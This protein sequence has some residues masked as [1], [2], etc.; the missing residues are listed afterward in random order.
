MS[1]GPPTQ[2]DAAGP[3]QDTHHP[4]DLVRVDG[5]TGA[6]HWICHRC[7]KQMLLWWPPDFKRTILVPG[8]ERAQHS[9]SKGG[10]QVGPVVTEVLPWSPTN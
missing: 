1:D 6:E 5:E 8:D 9:A 2:V 4:M 7:G 10:L 3:R